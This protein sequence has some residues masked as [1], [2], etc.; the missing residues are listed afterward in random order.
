V[1]DPIPP[2]VASQPAEAVELVSLAVSDGDLE[3]ALAQYQAGA[4]LRAWAQER[5]G[6]ADSV[7]DILIRLIDLRLPLS[8]E[9]RAI[10]QADGLAL[11]LGERT[12]VGTS[13]DCQRIQLT[14]TGATAVRRHQ[15]GSWL[16]VA[17]AWHLGGPGTGQAQG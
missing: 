8:V 2:P 16:I 5:D 7:A 13:P 14:G 12:I 11:V 4:V 6:D 15:G 10:V 3:G 9:I 17:D 1:P